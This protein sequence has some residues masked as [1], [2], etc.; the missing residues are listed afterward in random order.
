MG[1]NGSKGNTFRVAMTEI[2]CTNCLRPYPQQGAPFRCETCGGVFDFSSPLVFDEAKMVPGVRGMWRYRSAFG[3]EERAPAFTLGE[4][5][6]PLVWREVFG[7][8]VAFK[9]EYL[10][11]TGSFKDRGSAVLVSFL[12]SRGVQ[13]AV[14]DSSGNAGASFAAYAARAGM[15]ARIFIPDYASGPKRSQIEAYGADV[16]RI[17][18]PRSKTTEA[19]MREAEN[20]AVYASHAYMPHGLAGYATAAYEIF[21]QAGQAPG[22]V[23]VPAGQG[24][25]LLAIGRGFQALKNSGLIDRLPRLVGA[26]A[27]ACAPLWAVYKYGSA[28]LGWV[29]EGETLAEGVRIRHPVRG[30][31]LLNMIFEN[32]GSF[33]SVEEDAILDGRDE[34]ARLGFYVEPTSAIVWNALIQVMD[35]TPDPIVLVLTGSGYKTTS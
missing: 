30:D 32:D 20:G 35:E 23:I 12:R 6:T 28:G 8:K 18:G 10:N 3:L 27:L 26:Q 14:E 7:R 34:L 33:V 21:E 16:Q 22:T 2:R 13:A 1:R 29:T 24:N 25:F 19:V 4:G 5:D 17:L 31:I 11:P 15:Q 9:L